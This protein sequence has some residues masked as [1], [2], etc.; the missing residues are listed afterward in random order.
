MFHFTKSAVTIG[1]VYTDNT[2]L[3]DE[4]SCRKIGCNYYYYF[5]GCKKE[6]TALRVLLPK[7]SGP[8]KSFNDAMTMCFIVK[9]EKLLAK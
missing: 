5:F 2:I 3:F 6:V 8:V 4:Y 9:D 7:M 1:H